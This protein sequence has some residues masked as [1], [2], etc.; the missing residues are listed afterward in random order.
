MDDLKRFEELVEENNKKAEEVIKEIEEAFLRISETTDKIGQLAIESWGAQY[1]VVQALR[2]MKKD[3]TRVQGGVIE[4]IIESLLIK[5]SMMAQQQIINMTVGP[6]SEE[7]LIAAT[8]AVLKK[9]RQ[10]EGLEN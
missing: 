8:R 7:I 6:V 10:Q 3:M 4:K 5:T 9:R 1:I 2:Q